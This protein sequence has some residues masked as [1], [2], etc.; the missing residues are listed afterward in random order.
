MGL[1]FSHLTSWIPMWQNRP[2]AVGLGFHE[3]SAGPR[4]RKPGEHHL[5]HVPSLD[6]SRH[7]GVFTSHK[8]TNE[9]PLPEETAPVEAL[10]CGPRW[11]AAEGS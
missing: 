4:E 10:W 3:I 11:G 5:Y 2:D 9:N 1:P 8:W 7:H 6:S